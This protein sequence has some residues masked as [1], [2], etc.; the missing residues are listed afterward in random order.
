MGEYTKR[1]G[2]YKPDVGETGWGDK[3]N[4]NFDLIDKI[5]HHLED[6]VLRV[7]LRSLKNSATI[8]VT[9][10]ELY[11]VFADV[12]TPNYP[13]G[14]LNTINSVY[15]DD[16]WQALVTNPNT[17][18]LKDFQVEVIITDPD[19]FSLCTDPKYIEVYSGDLSTPL[20]FYV[21]HFDPT[22]SRCII[23][24]KVPL[25]KAGETIKIAIKVNTSRTESLSDPNEVFDFFDDFNTLSSDYVNVTGTWGASNGFAIVTKDYGTA[26]GN[27]LL[28]SSENVDS[29]KYYAEIIAILNT[30]PQDA[31]V[32]V[33][34]QGLSKDKPFA[35][36]GCTIISGAGKITIGYWNGSAWNTNIVPFNVALG[37]RYR[38]SL[39]IENGQ[40]IAKVRNLVN[41]AYKEVTYN[42]PF[43]SGYIGLHHGAGFTTSNKFD[44]LRL[45]KKAD[46]DPD[47]QVSKYLLY[48]ETKEFVTSDTFDTILITQFG[49][50][51]IK[52]SIDGGETWNEVEED[53]ETEIGDTNRIKLRFEDFNNFEGY[54]LSV[55]RST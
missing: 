27:V 3:V 26:P 22:N 38:V 25:I 12:I 24:V 41:W 9:G 35:V 11:N 1:F 5:L 32:V 15:S 49:D 23:F 33:G 50:A 13:N 10:K 6:N 45:R 47:V 17:Y 53:T 14:Y 43:S 7:A 54:A 20:P 4:H 40:L 18:D 30:S 36:S 44:Q 51:T 46:Q 55:W 28:N 39:A 16:T 29:T 19:F 2:L 42:V 21:E 34:A 31:S 37:Q 8:G 48:L 52:Y